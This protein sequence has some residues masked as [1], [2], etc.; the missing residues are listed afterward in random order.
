[1][2]VYPYLM[3]GLVL[4]LNFGCGRA[5]KSTQEIANDDSAEV[6]NEY[7]T[8]LTTVYTYEMFKDSIIK[9]YVDSINSY[10]AGSKLPN[11]LRDENLDLRTN[12]NEWAK[13]NFVSLRE[14]IFNK[15]DNIDLLNE[16]L[17]NSYF[18]HQF[19]DIEKRRE[20]IPSDNVSNFLLAKERLEK[21]QK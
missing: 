14:E 4:F 17:K 16:I 5:A 21:L 18:E 2:K 10:K 19:E 7:Q 12:I 1:M 20:R 13:T 11:F 8:E 9:P 6:Q 3:F 15:V